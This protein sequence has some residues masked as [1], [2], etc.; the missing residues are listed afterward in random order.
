[1]PSS[2]DSVR[3]AVTGGGPA[4]LMAAEALARRGAQVD[5]Y[6]A[7]PSVG[8]K[9]LMAGKGGMNITHS[10]PLEPFL[11]RYGARREQIAPLL[12]VFGPDALRA[13]LQ[14]LG[15]ETFVGSSGRVFPADMKAAPMLRAWLHRLREAGVQFHMRHKWNGWSPDAAD[16]ATHTL[17][18]ATPDG[19]QTVTC[20]AVVFALG[21][22]SW[23]R[24]GSD[25]AWVPLMASREVPVTPL[26]PANCGFDADWSPY[27]RERFAGQPIKPVAITLTDVD[28]KVHHRQG[29]ILL[30]ETGL[31]GSLIYALSAAIR[32]RILADGEV[33]I[34]LDL[35]PG[36]TLERV[37]AEVTRPRGSRS[38][39]SHL[40]GR[41]GIGGVKLALLHEIL[42]KEAFADVDGLA[43]AVKALPVRL[44]RARPI[45]EAISTA[46]GIP[47]E[48]LDAH[49]MIERLP[50]VFCAGEMLDWEAPT[51]GYLLTACF[52]SGLVAGRGALAYLK[53]LRARDA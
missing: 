19:E 33:T 28:N 41:I 13:W 49:L 42:S 34:A 17:R 3:V 4:G 18:F 15:I 45:A 22:A 14:G 20:D 27:L 50:G 51:G 36:L 32:E 44:T 21:G 37:V 24:L 23:P 39:A 7:M 47:F 30:T 9:F 12:D 25:A 1:M 29:E 53:A 31:E 43:R 52:A 6:D 11:G 8:R 48:A 10:E 26:R 16:T 46:G 35:V 38:M 5:V 2:F 40:H